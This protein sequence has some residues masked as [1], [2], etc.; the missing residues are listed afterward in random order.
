[1]EIAML[2]LSRSLWACLFAFALTTNAFAGEK[3]PTRHPEAARA[4]VHLQEGRDA[5]VNAAVQPFTEIEQRAFDRASRSL[6]W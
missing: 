6:G 1:M 5:A 2:T 4:A 3:G